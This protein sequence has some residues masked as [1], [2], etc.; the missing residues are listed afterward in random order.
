LRSAKR[1]ERL[2]AVKQNQNPTVKERRR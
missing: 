1:S 2:E